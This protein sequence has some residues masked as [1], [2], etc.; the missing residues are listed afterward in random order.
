VQVYAG[1]VLGLDDFVLLDS[2]LI[3]FRD[4]QF[5]ASP[6][7]NHSSKIRAYYYT[8][9]NQFHRPYY[10]CMKRVL[11]FGLPEHKTHRSGITHHMVI[12]RPV[13]ESLMDDVEALHGIPLW[14]ALLNQR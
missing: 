8:T 1:K 14:K 6:S 5:V 2:D 4:V 12:S 7:T 10:E 3:W 13:M 9:S 11:G